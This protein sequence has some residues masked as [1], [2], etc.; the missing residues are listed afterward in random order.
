MAA[1]CQMH[2]KSGWKRDQEAADLGF[3]SQKSSFKTGGVKASG[4]M[5]IQVVWWLNLINIGH[6]FS[7][8]QLRASNFGGLLYGCAPFSDP[9]AR[10]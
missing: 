5:N 6:L 9:L 8:G 10:I 1:V 2:Y 7:E 4:Y 3:I